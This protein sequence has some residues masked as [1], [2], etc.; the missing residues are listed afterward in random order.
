MGRHPATTE[1]I[2]YAGRELWSAPRSGRRRHDPA[3]GEPIKPAP[4]AQD[5][6]K[7]CTHCGETKSIYQFYANPAGRVSSECIKCK[8]AASSL[9]YHVQHCP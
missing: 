2:V 9:R 8:R 1:E 4:H 6:T 3:T 5:D 7:A